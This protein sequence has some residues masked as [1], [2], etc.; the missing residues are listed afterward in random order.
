[1]ILVVSVLM[2]L[3]FDSLDKDLDILASVVNTVS[4]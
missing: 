1:M 4:V 3:S 2:I